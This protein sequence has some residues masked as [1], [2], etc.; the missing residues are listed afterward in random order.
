MRKQWWDSAYGTHPHYTHF[1]NNAVWL[2]KQARKYAQNTGAPDVAIFDW[3]K[4]FIFNFYGMAEHLQNPVLAK[5]IWPSFKF[6]RLEQTGSAADY[7]SE[8]LWL[9]SKISRET[10]L[11][12]VARKRVGRAK[13]VDEYT[14]FNDGTLAST[15]AL[16]DSWTCCCPPGHPYLLSRPPLIPV[17]VDAV[18][19]LA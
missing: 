10:H 13:G 16:D 11:F 7:A 5:G 18:D 14:R 17:A 4:M 3:D 6:Q 2:S 8:F 19:I 12:F 1:T 15:I 9:S